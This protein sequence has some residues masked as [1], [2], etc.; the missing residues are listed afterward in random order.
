M[1][2]MV[3]EWF[4]WFI[5]YS[6]L[7]W[8]YESFICSIGQKRLINRGFLNGPVCPVYGFGALVTILFIGQRI[9]NIVV[10][11]FTGMILTCTVE[12]I[13]AVLLEKLFDAKW[14][15]YSHHRFNIQGRVS[16]LGAVVFGV[17]SVFLIKYIHP[18]VG[19]V[20][21][22]LPDW[23]QIALSLIIT[24]LLLLDLYVT[25]RHLLSLNG[26]LKEIQSVINDFLEQYAKRAGEIKDSIL[27]KFENSEFYNDHIKTLFVLNKIQNIRII[28]AFPKLQSTKYNDAFQKLKNILL[29]KED[30][31]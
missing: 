29:G 12:Y 8:V 21:G 23:T 27:D 22:R 11:F 26:R 28:K 3:I 2:M 9:D 16:L 7:G 10:L 14:W 24:V 1:F 20:I 18:F 25:V 30:N 17:L 4:L 15:D 31:E 13:T 19:G 5:A 6:F